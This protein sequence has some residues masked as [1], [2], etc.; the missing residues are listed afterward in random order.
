MILI[1]SAIVMA[2]CKTLEPFSQSMRT[3]VAAARQWTGNGVA[4]VRRGSVSEA[5]DY[6]TKASS[7][8]PKDHEIVVNLARTHFQEGQ[9]Q[10]AIKELNRAIEINGPDEKLLVEL[11]QYLLAD[12]QVDAASEKVQ[13][14]LQ[15]NHRHAGAWLLSGKI[16]A[17]KGDDQTALGD[18][19]KAIGIDPS[20]ED[21]QL[22]IVRGYRRLN[23][24]L[25]AL[26]AVENILEQYPSHHQPAAAI[27]EKSQALVQLKQNKS[28]IETLNQAIAAGNK[29]P[30]IGLALSQLSVD[31]A[32]LRI[33]GKSGPDQALTR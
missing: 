31:Q 14:A 13:Q 7:Q 8:L 11:G 20:R 30:E 19:Q 29:S 12:G 1:A 4:A 17:A 21:I 25:R 32:D 33:A 2:G 28:A 27:V 24:P 23:D 3:R 26:S 15:E 16:H 10:P 5:R 18:F 6:F 22:E 9:F